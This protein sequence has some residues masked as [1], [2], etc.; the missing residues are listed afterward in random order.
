MKSTV[1]LL[2]IMVL[3]TSAAFADGEMGT[4]GKTCPANTTCLTEAPPPGETEPINTESD[5]TILT[6]VQKYLESM[7]EYFAD[8]QQ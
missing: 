2:L 5:D 7:F 6:Y 3:F 8:P 4:N 1:K